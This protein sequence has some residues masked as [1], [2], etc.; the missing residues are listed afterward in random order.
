M[1]VEMEVKLL[2]GNV[3]G[4]EICY[5]INEYLRLNQRKFSFKNNLY[6]VAAY[7]PRYINTITEYMKLNILLSWLF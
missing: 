1:D 4:Y 7:A 2:F 5:W 3:D 6:E